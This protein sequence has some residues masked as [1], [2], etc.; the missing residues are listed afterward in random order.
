MHDYKE[1][2]VGT[3]GFDGPPGRTYAKLSLVEF[4][5]S[6]RGNPSAKS[7]RRLRRA[8][9]G[10]F[11]FVARASAALTHAG[12]PAVGRLKLN[13]LPDGRLPDAA[14]DTGELGQAAWQWTLETART[15]GAEAVYWQTP[16]SFRPTPANRARLTA[17]LEQ[18]RGD[19]DLTLCWDSQGLWERHEQ[20]ALCADLGLVPCYDP[21]L[22][23]TPLPGR[24]YLR[25]LGKAR[26]THGLSADEL[27]RLA[28]AVE[29]TES[30][31]VALHTPRPFRDARALLTALTGG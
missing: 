30:P 5:E 18:V 26:S 25:V 16:A 22:E 20:V 27:Y 12:E 8:A 11:S 28:D 17:F 1:P 31:R 29:A 14:L 9:G 10:D 2:R 24:A 21:L 7:L 19:D 4:Q 23:D 6:F 15:L 3:V 13:Y